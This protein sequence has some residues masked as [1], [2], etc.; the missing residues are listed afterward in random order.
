MIN[1]WHVCLCYELCWYRNK[2]WSSSSLVLMLTQ[3]SW[4][5]IH[6]I[7]RVNQ[8]NSSHLSIRLPNFTF[9]HR[10]GYLVILYIYFRINTDKSYIHI[11]GTNDWRSIWACR[12]VWSTN[13][14]Y[15]ILFLGKRPVV[16]RCSAISV[17]ADDGT[18]SLAAF[19]L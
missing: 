12:I 17:L 16:L 10:A 6:T 9:T 13:T 15:A 2:S 18:I 5:T 11:T 3:N 7:L 4:C 19:P 8:C 14:P 1:P